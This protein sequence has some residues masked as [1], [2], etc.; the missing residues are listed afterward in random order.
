MTNVIGLNM[1]RSPKDKSG[2]DQDLK[3]EFKT[4]I[5]RRVVDHYK[6]LPSS[7]PSQSTRTITVPTVNDS[8]LQVVQVISNLSMPT[9]IA[10]LGPDDFLMLLKEGTVFRVTNGTL[11]SH[12]FS[13]L[14]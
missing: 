3:F 6:I 10:F 11:S 14:V 7:D 9:T 2:V 8:N 13:T 4:Q 12:P 1:I 5:K